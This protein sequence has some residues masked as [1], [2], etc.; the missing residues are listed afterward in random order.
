MHSPFIT[1]IVVSKNRKH[2]LI[3]A[4]D[5]VINQTLDKSLY[6]IIVVQNPGS[7]EL[8]NSLSEKGV[9]VLNVE[10][11]ST[12]LKVSEA[13]KISHGD[14]ISFLEDDD[15]FEEN[16]LQEIYDLFQDPEVG[17][18]H[19]S[20]TA[21]DSYGNTLPGFK[22]GNC[23][24]SVYIEKRRF[25]HRIDS[26]LRH[27]IDFNISS[28]SVRKRILEDTVQYWR[29]MAATS[30]TFLFYSAI[31]SNM[32][33]VASDKALTRYRIHANSL[34]NYL[35]GFK[36]FADK[37]INLLRSLI[38]DYKIIMRMVGNTGYEKFVK[39]VMI[40][41]IMSAGIF[42][43]NKTYKLRLGDYFSIFRP[44]SMRELFRYDLFLLIASFFSK[45]RRKY[46]IRAAYAHY[47]REMDAIFSKKK[48]A[49]TTDGSSDCLIH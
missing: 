39:R 38:N 20:I 12:G 4:V 23:E 24:R 1:L 26:M 49:K 33:I 21:I 15:V 25:K 44:F 14:V 2:F 9:N 17:Y 18:V 22:K 43:N 36:G 6:E 48:L 28:I 29:Q 34:T 27:N 47:V 16:K 3:E 31:V 32:T 41:K 46:V 30:D 8:E 5:S 13:L 37:K 11:K 45:F 35:G 7:R 19:N 42:D 10:H 40:Q